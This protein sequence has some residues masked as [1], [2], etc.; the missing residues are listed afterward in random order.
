MIQTTEQGGYLVLVTENGT[1][2]VRKDSILLP[3]LAK[4]LE[5][6]AAPKPEPDGNDA[7]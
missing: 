4:A 7:N 6:A 2:R 3:V 1:W 5:E